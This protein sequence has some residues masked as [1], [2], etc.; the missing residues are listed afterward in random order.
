MTYF[1]S[2]HDHNATDRGT[3]QDKHNVPKGG[4]LFVGET[5]DRGRTI[6]DEDLAIDVHALDDSLGLPIHQVTRAPLQERIRD[7]TDAVVRTSDEE[8]DQNDHP[9]FLAPVQRQARTREKE[10]SSTE[11]HD[12]P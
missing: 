4:G 12:V 6:V 5:L 10:R 3:D 1:S 8:H 2:R 11:A 9:A 7:D